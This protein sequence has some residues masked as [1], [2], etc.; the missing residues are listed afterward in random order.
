[1]CPHTPHSQRSL[2]HRDGIGEPKYADNLYR[3]V[4]AKVCAPGGLWREAGVRLASRPRLTGVTDAS[5]IQAAVR[6]ISGVASRCSQDKERVAGPRVRE[7]L[8]SSRRS[9]RSPQQH[10]GL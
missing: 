3:G 4:E 7:G 9:R 1:M 8:R 10:G 2:W 6:P 5:E